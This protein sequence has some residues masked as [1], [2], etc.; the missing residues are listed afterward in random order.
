MR[1]ARDGDYVPR[2]KGRPE[3]KCLEAIYCFMARIL[4]P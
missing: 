4:V 1:Q 2:L 3:E